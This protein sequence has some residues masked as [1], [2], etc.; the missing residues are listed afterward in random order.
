MGT[1]FPPYRYSKRAACP[2]SAELTG[3]G[4][5]LA[6]VLKRGALL[7]DS[8]FPVT[9]LAASVGNRHHPKVI[10]S[11]DIRVQLYGFALSRNHAVEGRPVE[12]QRRDRRGGKAATK[13]R[14]AFGVGGA[15]S[16]SRAR[17][18]VRERQQ[19]G[20]TPNA[21]RGRS[22]GKPVRKTP[23][24]PSAAWMSGGPI[25]SL[26]IRKRSYPTRK[27]CNRSRL[28]DQP[29][30]HPVATPGCHRLDTVGAGRA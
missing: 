20:R 2:G 25:S 19:A 11:V 24:A 21:A 1:A 8:L 12:P 18:T 4:L 22:P 15:C 7:V 23:Q 27:C 5:G 26:S 16:R 30:V 3:G 6:R 13:P 29:R 14:E 17:G 28:H 10:G 9:R